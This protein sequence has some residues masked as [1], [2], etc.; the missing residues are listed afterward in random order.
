M[1]GILVIASIFQIWLSNIL[2]GQ[3]ITVKGS[4]TVEIVGYEWSST[5]LKFHYWLLQH[6]LIVVYGGNMTIGIDKASDS[7]YI[8]LAPGT[9]FESEEVGP[10]IVLD[11][12][13][14]GTVIAIEL[15]GI[16]EHLPSDAFSKVEVLTGTP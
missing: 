6:S 12:D 1:C 4:R 5:H 16:S 7:A 11:F 2:M 13:A 15:L 3:S 8:R 14:S 10:G 9:P